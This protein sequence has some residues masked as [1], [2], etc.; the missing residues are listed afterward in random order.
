VQQSA[1]FMC[2][3]DRFALNLIR[4]ARQT[5]LTFRFIAGIIPTS[6]N[7]LLSQVTLK[8]AMEIKIR[9]WTREDLVEIRRAWLSFC[10]N[11]DRSDMAIRRDADSAMKHWLESRFLEPDTFGLVAEARSLLAGFLVARVGDWESSP[12]IVTPRRIGIVD[13]VYVSEE[14]RRQGIGNRLIDRALELMRKENATAV[15]TIYDMSDEPADRTWRR[16][17]FSPWMVHAYRML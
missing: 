11:V 1:D 10:R 12:P 13:A 6:L 4:H 2:R 14:F 15:E 5:S 7:D 9:N 17:G 3:V 16:A 8:F